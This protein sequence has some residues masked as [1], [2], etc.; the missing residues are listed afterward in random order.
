MIVKSGE[1]LATVVNDVLDYSKLESGNVEIDI[2]RSNLQETLHAV[3]HS[4]SMKAK[5]KNIALRTKLDPL[6]PEFI[7]TDGRRLQQVLFNLLGN[8]VKFSEEGSVVELNV[9]VCDDEAKDKGFTYKSDS[10]SV[11]SSTWE[12]DVDSEAGFDMSLGTRS[13]MDVAKSGVVTPPSELS[14]S[15]F[16]VTEGLSPMLQSQSFCTLPGQ[17]S[18]KV[19]RFVV[20]DYGKGIDEAEYDKIFKPFAQVRSVKLPESSGFRPTRTFSH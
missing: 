11:V 8:A 14:S 19:L 4:I 9:L 7:R 1:L 10:D 3:V 6:L 16:M 12:S 17:T 5:S 20:K 2:Q 18:E 13:D 15:A